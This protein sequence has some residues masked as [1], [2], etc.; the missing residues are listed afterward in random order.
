M[1]FRDANEMLAACEKISAAPSEFDA[2]VENGRRRA[3]ADHTWER[4]M[5][6]ILDLAKQRFDLPW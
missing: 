2:V 1:A 5:E 4:R 3:M 6:R